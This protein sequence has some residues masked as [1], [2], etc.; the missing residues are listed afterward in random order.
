[1]VGDRLG[2]WGVRQ[3]VVR[4]ALLCAACGAELGVSL[5]RCGA[6]ELNLDG[7]SRVVPGQGTALDDGVWE[8][9]VSLETWFDR[10]EEV[11]LL[12]ETECYECARCA[13]VPVDVR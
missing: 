4:S 2:S 12:D 11:V 9:L 3:R 8:T 1:V 10:D 13:D 7:A 5:L 6:E